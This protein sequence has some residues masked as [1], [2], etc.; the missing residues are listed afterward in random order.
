M[1]SFSIWLERVAGRTSNILTKKKYYMQVFLI[2][3]RTESVYFFLKFVY[4]TVYLSVLHFFCN[5][6]SSHICFDFVH[7]VALILFLARFSHNELSW[8]V[9]NT[10]VADSVC[11]CFAKII[12]GHEVRYC[13]DFRF[14]FSFFS[15]F[16]FASIHVNKCKHLYHYN[17]YDSIAERTETKVKKHDFKL[18]TVF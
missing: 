2:K 14:S 9:I 12:K 3:T 16:V 1:L 6:N 5:S 7:V 15:F 8:K 11:A 18:D 17:N 4:S 10:D 13:F